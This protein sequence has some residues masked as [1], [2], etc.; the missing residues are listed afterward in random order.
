MR[1]LQFFVFLGVL[2][3]SQISRCQDE[4]KQRNNEIGINFIPLI[5][6][7]Y[8]AN[9]PLDY[10]LTFRHTHN[11][12]YAFRSSLRLQLDEYTGFIGPHYSRFYREEISTSGD[13]T[14]Y[15]S[16]YYQRTKSFAVQL[17]I[18]RCFQ[19]K[20]TELYAG[21]S[22][23][24]GLVL[25]RSNNYF[26]T[27]LKVEGGFENLVFSGIDNTFTYSTF[28]IGLNPY[29]GWR[30]PIAKRFVLSVQ[31]ATF[32]AYH[33]LKYR[34]DLYAPVFKAGNVNLSIFPLIGEVSLNWKI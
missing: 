26:E 27:Y 10:S 21:A 11:E 33:F 8:S 16:S 34:S 25:N 31:T 22:I 12:K 5:Q 19:L 13:E 29:V 14:M 24:P 20:R 30:V 3:L 17:G 2:P 15:R 4:F 6:L 18:E 9:F 28:E 32:W 1:P 7:A 23:S